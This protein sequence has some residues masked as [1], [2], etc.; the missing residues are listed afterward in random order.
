MILAYFILL[1]LL[2]LPWPIIARDNHEYLSKEQTSVIKGAFVV[3]VLLCHFNSYVELSNNLPDRL[4]LRVTGLIG[5]LCVV[6]FLFYSGYGIYSSFCKKADYAR[7]FLKKRFLPVYLSFAF[8]VGL[9][10]IENAIFG[11]KY[12]VRENILAFTGWESIGNS[13]WFMF[14]TFI[15]YL[16]FF[17]CFGVLKKSKYD[18]LKLI[19]FSFFCIL[20]VGIL[21]FTKD[22]DWWYNTLLCFPLGMWYAKYKEHIDLLVFRSKKN[23]ALAL[24]VLL[25]A[26]VGFF[27]LCRKN[28]IFYIIYS[29]IFALLV[30]CITMKVRFR[31]RVLAFLGQHV[32]SIYMLQR[33]PYRIGE[34]YGINKFPYVYLLISGIATIV[35]ALIYDRLY[36]KIKKSLIH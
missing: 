35:I 21:F 4:F 12:S 10:A 18:Y 34:Y 23:Y 31:S 6:M 13:N 25:V 17:L 14:E 20:F 5:Q 9:F 11:W 27:L 24:I 7:T 36:G 26:F 15:L 28:N 8:C 22:G 19:A 2:F 33:L 30:T 29:M 16:L 3:V 1:L 32:F